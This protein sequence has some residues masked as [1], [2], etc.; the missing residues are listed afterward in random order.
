M[1]F[2]HRNYNRY[3]VIEDTVAAQVDG[4]LED[5]ERG[6]KRSF[7]TRDRDSVAARDGC[8][9]VAGWPKKLWG[10]VFLGLATFAFYW[11]GQMTH[12]HQNWNNDEGVISGFM[13]GLLW[14][15]AGCLFIFMCIFSCCYSNED[16]GEMNAS[17]NT[18]GMAT[19]S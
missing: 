19:F 1:R 6:P 9:Y 10:V 2:F 3:R 16:Y 8:Y 15:G 11:G 12:E 14:L 4:E 17:L 5:E 13:T 18:I 7:F